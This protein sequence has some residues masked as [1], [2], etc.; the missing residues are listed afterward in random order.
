LVSVLVVIALTT[1]AMTGFLTVFEAQAKA[2]RTLTA[3]GSVNDLSHALDTLFASPGCA[4]S[5]GFLANGGSAAVTTSGTTYALALDTLRF[6]SGTLALGSDPAAAGYTAMEASIQPYQVSGIAL[7][8]LGANSTGVNPIFPFE[9]TVTFSNRLGPPPLPLTKFIRVYTTGSA[10]PYAVVGACYQ[11]TGSP[12]GFNTLVF[13]SPGVS[14][15]T[16]PQGVST[17]IAEVWGAGGGACG[18]PG[19]AGGGGGYAYCVIPVTPG[20]VYAVTV[21]AGGPA[22][23]TYPNCTSTSDGATSSFTGNAIQCSATGGTQGNGQFRSSPGTNPGGAGIGGIGQNGVLNLAGGDGDD[24]APAPNNW[25]RGGASP[26]GGEGGSQPNTIVQMDGKWP[27]GG[28]GVSW[29]APYSGAGAAGG[30]VLHW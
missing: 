17:I 21:G 30:V 25:G 2:T 12:L 18:G 29:N 8:P 9:L 27:G 10:S 23:G 5:G 24:T 28:G 7:A 3:S 20:Q 14:Q 15:W 13:S 11:G 6:A 4:S 1:M 22:A 26:R 16:V 19:G